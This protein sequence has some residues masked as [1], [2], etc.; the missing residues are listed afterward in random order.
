MSESYDVYAIGNALVDT[1]IEVSDDFLASMQIDKGMMTLVDRDRQ[2][3][4]I[5]ALRE[6]AEPHKQASGGSAANTI[7]ATRYFGGRTYY[8]CKVAN[9]E[10]GDFYVRDLRAA[11]VATNMMNGARPDGISGTCLVMITPD[12]ERTMN[13]FLGISETVSE[14][15][16][17]HDALRA[18]KYAYI[19]GY[20]VT[21][22][23]AR[24]AAIRMR[25]AAR[26]YG[27]RTAMTLSDPAMVKFFA[28]GLKEMLGDGVDLLF[29][30]QD[31]A[32]GFTG[33]DNTDDAIDALK[34][35]A[36]S[37]VMTRGAKGA[38]VF[39]GNRLHQI[40]AQPVKAIDTN[41]AGDM[42]AGAFLYAITHDQSLATAGR[43]A[44]AASARV[45]SDFGPRIS[46]EAH[47]EIRK[48]ILGY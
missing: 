23:S 26:E 36:G 32:F 41:G 3:A 11:G 42:F 17:D 43:L 24:Q 1:E 27:V 18:S 48:Q 39:D 8:T 10:T 29:C 5:D 12:A 35:H 16:I 21:S 2:L 4:L 40:D 13:S 15:E 22:P 30:N 46:A 31:E 47:L 14:D 9:D 6:H 34:Q 25:E 20:L 7:I 37:I 38:L 33:A 28:D 19:E 45:V 44:S